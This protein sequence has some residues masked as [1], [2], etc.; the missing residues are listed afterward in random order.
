MKQVI[1][2]S[3]LQPSLNG[4]SLRAMLNIARIRNAADGLSGILLYHSGS[5]V[6]VIEG[7]DPHVSSTFGRILRDPRHS[8]I[9]ILSVK[10]IDAPEFGNSPMAFFDKN[11]NRPMPAG[12]MAEL[13]LRPLL[14]LN[15][16]S[17]RHLLLTLKQLTV[18]EPASTGS[19]LQFFPHKRPAAFAVPQFPTLE[20][21]AVQ[22]IM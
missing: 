15:E 16:T 7:T 2:T 6:Q 12:P 20:P 3:A 1:Y 19:L 8:S 14:T 13:H 11:Q 18:S 10:E 4:P 22:G 17:A 21:L 5:L 9:N